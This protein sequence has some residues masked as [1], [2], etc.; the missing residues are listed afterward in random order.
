[1]K[2][3]FTLKKMNESGAVAYSLITNP[4]ELEKADP[5]YP[6]MPVNAATV[7]S[8]MSLR[9]AVSEPIAAFLRP[10]ELRAFTE[11]VKRAE[12]SREN[13]LLISPT[14]SGVLRLSS[15]TDGRREKQTAAYY[16][17]RKREENPAGLRKT[18]EACT[19]FVPQLADII[20]AFAGKSDLDKE[21]TLYLETSKGEEYAQGAPGNVGSEEIETKELAQLR[22]KRAAQ[23]SQLFKEMEKETTGQKGLIKTFSACLS[24]HGCRQVCPICHCFTCVFDSQIHESQPWSLERELE[25]KAGTRLPAGTLFFQ[26][27]RMAHMAVSCVNCGMCSDVCPVNI[28]VAEIFSMVGDSL[29]KVL[30]YFPGRDIEEAVPSGA[31]KEAEFVEMGE[32]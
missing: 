17:S 26:L 16:E 23:R 6:L 20:V 15:S 24:C 30:E 32:L 10:C 13:L 1:M 14:C 29:Q 25:H 12:G 28:P 2:G 4:E 9:E 21:C 19:S 11:L 27:G 5:L 8:E 31:Y 3:I 22:E 18:C 7:L